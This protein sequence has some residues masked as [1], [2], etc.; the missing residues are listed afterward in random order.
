MGVSGE[1][2]VMKVQFEK[3]FIELCKNFDERLRRIEQYVMDQE[4]ERIEKYADKLFGEG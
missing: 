4:L 1:P 3:E 2:L